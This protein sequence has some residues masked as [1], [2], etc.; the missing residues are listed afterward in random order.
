MRRF[1]RVEQRRRRRFGEWLRAY[2]EKWGF[3][4]T[5]VANEVGVSRQY[6]SA[7]ENGQR[8]PTRHMAIVLGR[9]FW[10]DGDV[11]VAAAGFLPLDLSEFLQ[12]RPE[13]IKEIREVCSRIRHTKEQ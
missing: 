9:V 10:L 13:A 5:E 1:Y 4:V 12:E 11:V 8:C 2:R 3:T 6:V 7:I